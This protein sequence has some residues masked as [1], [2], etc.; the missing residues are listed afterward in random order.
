ME[1][2]VGDLSLNPFVLQLALIFAPGLL[3]ARMNS[4]FVLKREQGALNSLYPLF[5]TGS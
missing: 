3:W 2:K 1:G 5:S 4:V